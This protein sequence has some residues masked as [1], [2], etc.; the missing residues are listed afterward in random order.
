MTSSSGTDESSD[1]GKYIFKKLFSY[2]HKS[3]KIVKKM[4]K[5]CLG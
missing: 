2:L 1:D 4:T 3:L 5:R